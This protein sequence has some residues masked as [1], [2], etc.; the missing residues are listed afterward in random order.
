MLAGYAF[1]L[2]VDWPHWRDKPKQV[3]VAVVQVPKVRSIFPYFSEILLFSSSLVVVDYN[4]WDCRFSGAARRVTCDSRP[5]SHRQRAGHPVPEQ[6]G[7]VS[8]QLTH[9]ARFY[10]FM[11]N[12]FTKLKLTASFKWSH[13]REW[14]NKQLKQ[15]R[16]LIREI[17]RFNLQILLLPV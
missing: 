3:A 11:K 5:R 1:G 15:T 4:S 14:K 6:P 16:N 17:P 10:N 7:S 13:P 8:R 2:F 12:V 9:N